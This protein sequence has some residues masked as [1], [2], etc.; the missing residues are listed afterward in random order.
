MHD[1]KADAPIL[2]LYADHN[3]DDR[4]LVTEAFA[5]VAPE[6]RIVSVDDSKKLLDYLVLASSPQADSSA[7]LPAAVLLEINMPRRG[8]TDALMA[9]KANARTQQIPV[10]VFSTETSE[11]DKRKALKLGADLFVR[12]PRSF[13]QLKATLLEIAERLFK[14]FRHPSSI[15]AFPNLDHVSR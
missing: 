6:V 13:E 8:G 4:V 7:P 3:P 12:K 9:I 10:I 15:S 5:E 1:Y 14:G 2:I 11:K